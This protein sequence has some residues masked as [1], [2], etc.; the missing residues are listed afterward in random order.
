M[1]YTDACQ[2]RETL[3][4]LTGAADI[5]LEGSDRLS[6]DGTVLRSLNAVL[7]RHVTSR[8]QRHNPSAGWQVY[9]Q[10]VN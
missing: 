6:L 7:A 5:R 10:V 4:F 8:R 1:C 9:R 3:S 2:C